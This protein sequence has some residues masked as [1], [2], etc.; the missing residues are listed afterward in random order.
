MSVHTVSGALRPFFLTSRIHS[1]LLHYQTHLKNECAIFAWRASASPSM[2]IILKRSPIKPCYIDVRQTCSDL[3]N[4]RRKCPNSVNVLEMIW[5][6]TNLGTSCHICR[7]SQFARNATMMSSGLPLRLDQR[8][9]DLSTV[10]CKCCHRVQR[11]R[12][13][14]YTLIE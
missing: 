9:R 2:S 6:L 14:N 13:V 3:C 10:H 1:T 5:C 7:N 8:W 11:G 12:V 4:L